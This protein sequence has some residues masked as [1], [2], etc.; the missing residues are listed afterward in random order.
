MQLEGVNVT[1]QSIRSVNNS[2]IDNNSENT[3]FNINMNR[4][5]S[6][7]ILP[8]V[9]ALNRSTNNVNPNNTSTMSIKENNNNSINSKYC[10][11]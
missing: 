9:D 3:A 5:S 10:F 6:K 7:N 4:K 2:M 8:G 11:L 1:N